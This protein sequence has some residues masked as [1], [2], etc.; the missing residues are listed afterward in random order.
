MSSEATNLLKELGA[1][2]LCKWYQRI[3]SSDKP[4]M[5]INESLAIGGSAVYQKSPFI[6]VSDQP[7]LFTHMGDDIPIMIKKKKEGFRIDLGDTGQEKLGDFDGTVSSDYAIGVGDRIED[8]DA[9]K[10]K[11]LSSTISAS[12]E[13]IRLGLLYIP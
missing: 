11:V 5:L 6:H 8:P 13:F 7:T 1:S 2:S 3:S 4:P 9:K 10:Y 12:R